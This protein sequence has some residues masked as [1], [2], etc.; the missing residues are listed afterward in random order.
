MIPRLLA[1]SLRID[2]KLAERFSRVVLRCLSPTP[3]ILSLISVAHPFPPFP[4]SLLSTLPLG[5]TLRNL[6]CLPALPSTFV[7]TLHRHLF[8]FPGGLSSSRISSF[9]LG[10]ITSYSV[11]ECVTCST[12]W[13]RTLAR[14]RVYSY[15]TQLGSSRDTFPNTN[16]TRYPCP[17][18][19]TIV[20]TCGW[21]TPVSPVT[22]LSRTTWL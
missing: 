13:S 19:D 7:H 11:F 16:F 20:L 22:Y 5:L 18:T 8:P 6:N 9:V 10:K 3:W 14:L 21:N 17:S 12:S 2:F 15:L 4:P 1:F